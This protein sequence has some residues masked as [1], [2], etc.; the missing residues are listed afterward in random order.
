M[1]DGSDLPAERTIVLFPGDFTSG[2]FSENGPDLT[3]PIALDYRQRSP[4][5]GAK[6][7][8][9]VLFKDGMFTI[10]VEQVVPVAVFFLRS[11]AGALQDHRLVVEQNRGSTRIRRP[12]P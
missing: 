6:Q 3:V 2:Q 5:A 11:T 10:E 7:H 1:L 8:T 9:A 4:R 12:L